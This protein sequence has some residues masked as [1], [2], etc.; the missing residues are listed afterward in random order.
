VLYGYGPLALLMARTLAQGSRRLLRVAGFGVLAWAAIVVALPWIALRLAPSVR[1]PLYHAL[2]AGAQAPDWLPGAA[3]LLL[4]AGIVLW[5]RGDY[6]WRRPAAAA[7]AL[8]LFIGSFTVPWF[9]ETLQGPVG[10]AAAV[11][12]GRSEAV[13]MGDVRLPS[14]AVYLRRVVPGREAQPGE[15]I[16]TRVDRIHPQDAGR[17]RLFEERGIVLLGP[18][19]AP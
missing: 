14:F 15:L 10:R 11:A 8:A 16:F 17:P 4:V 18:R 3:V 5:P 19:P 2:L 12:A 13:V 9:G 7:A 6:D 1:D